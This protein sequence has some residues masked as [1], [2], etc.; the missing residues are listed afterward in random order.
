MYTA[1][2][3]CLSELGSRV[4]TPAFDLDELAD[5]LRALGEICSDRLPLSLN[6]EPATALA[7]STYTVVRNIALSW[8]CSIPP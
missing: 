6:A 7:R 3:E 5:K 2:G 4:K 1:G 8:H